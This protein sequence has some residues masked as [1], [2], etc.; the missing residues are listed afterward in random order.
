[1]VINMGGVVL[2]RSL[3]TICDICDNIYL[4]SNFPATYYP[5]IL[6]KGVTTCQDYPHL[7]IFPYSKLNEST[8]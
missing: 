1:M 7:T 4:H 2:V 6:P 5:K 8:Y 3:E